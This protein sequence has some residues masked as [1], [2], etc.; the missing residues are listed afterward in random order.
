MNIAF[1]TILLFIILAPGFIARHAYRSTK[2]SIN[3]PNRSIINDL[4]LSIIPAFL[5]Q[6]LANS[7]AF[8]LT[9]DY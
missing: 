7:Q 4:M 9:L 6:F 8:E 2:L 3:D 1:T 5:I